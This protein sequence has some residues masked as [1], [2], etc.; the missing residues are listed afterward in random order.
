ML[1]EAGVT[2]QEGEATEQKLWTLRQMYE[3]YAQVLSEYFFLAL[4]PW[5]NVTAIQDNWQGK[6]LA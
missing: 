6:S 5:F 1:A 3:P 4:P 2:L